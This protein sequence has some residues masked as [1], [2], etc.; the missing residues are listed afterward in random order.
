MIMQMSIHQVANIF[1]RKL[2]EFLHKNQHQVS[3]VSAHPFPSY[4][5]PLSL[6]S[7]VPLGNPE[8]F[9]YGTC[10]T[11]KIPSTTTFNQIIVVPLFTHISTHAHSNSSYENPAHP[12]LCSWLGILFQ[13]SIGPTS[14]TSYRQM[15]R[16]MAT[17]RCPT[18]D[19]AP[20][21]SFLICMILSQKNGEKD[22]TRTGA[23]YTDVPGKFLITKYWWKLRLGWDKVVYARGGSLFECLFFCF[24]FHDWWWRPPPLSSLL[25]SEW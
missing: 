18:G 10:P 17:G 25:G 14:H 13:R 23:Q 9:R 15:A 1:I 19:R 2:L 4:S 6:Q 12:C 20:C 11:E 8:I 3:F 7:S 22:G 24:F 16:P 5:I 21:V